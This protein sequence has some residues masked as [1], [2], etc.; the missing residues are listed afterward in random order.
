ML[1]FVDLDETGRLFSSMDG[2]A[3]WTVNVIT[4]SVCSDP[5]DPAPLLPRSS[6]YAVFTVPNNVTLG[7]RLIVVGGDNLQNHVYYSDDC[8]LSWQ[9]YD[10][11]Q[12]WVP[13]NFA[14]SFTI[15]G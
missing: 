8:G 12:E 5:A 6:G 15:P 13:R 14:T 1:Y 2:R 7:D 11:P 9:C 3:P 4:A 10:G